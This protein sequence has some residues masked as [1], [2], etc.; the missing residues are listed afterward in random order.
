VILDAAEGEEFYVGIAA[1]LE[2]RKK[3]EVADD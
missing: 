3:V 2:R 1:R